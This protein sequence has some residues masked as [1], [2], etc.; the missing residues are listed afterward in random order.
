MSKF[1]SINQYLSLKEKNKILL[2]ENVRIKNQLS[3]Y[4]LKKDINF[5]KHN[6]YYLFNSAR[7]INNSV[8]KRNNFLTLNKGSKDGIKIGQ[9]VVIKDGIIGIVKSV[10]KNYSVVI[11]ILNKKT[12]VSIKFKKNNYVGS[13]KWNGYNYMKGEVRDVMNHI[14][15]SVGDTIVTSGY[16]T[17]FPKDIKIGVVSKIKN[18]DNSGYQKIEVNFLKDLNM[19][20]FVYVVEAKNKLEILKLQKSFDD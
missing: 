8:F 10:S 17:I 9:G 2:N 18:R 3:R 15:I 11:S 7:V 4:N 13:L 16:G 20:D 5:V 12:N 19:I 6:D 1:S 14:D